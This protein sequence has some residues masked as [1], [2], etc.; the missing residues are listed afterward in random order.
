MLNER[1][2]KLLTKSKKHAITIWIVLNIYILITIIISLWGYISR[3]VKSESFTR[4][5]KTVMT[6]NLI[7]FTL[8]NFIVIATIIFI[9]SIRKNQSD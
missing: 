6:N 8:G 7:V 4:L 5:Y 2:S 9:K 1:I 3:D